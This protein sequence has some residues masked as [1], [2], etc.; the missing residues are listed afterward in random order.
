VSRAYI[1]FTDQVRVIE[2]S[3]AILTCVQWIA[4]WQV[5]LLL[6]NRN[7]FKHERFSTNI[8]TFSHYVEMLVWKYAWPFYVS[9]CIYFNLHTYM[10]SYNPKKVEER[11]RYPQLSKIYYNWD[12]ASTNASPP[13]CSPSRALLHRNIYTYINTTNALSFYVAEAYL[14]FFQGS[15]VLS[16]WLWYKKYCSR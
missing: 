6:A 12:M 8:S 3:C 14:V 1:T 15:Y 16:K 9:M 13:F 11:L 5:A 4:T 10:K 2:H 7:C